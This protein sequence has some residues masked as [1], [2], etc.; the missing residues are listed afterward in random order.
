MRQMADEASIQ[1]L[2]DPRWQGLAACEVF[3]DPGRQRRPRAPVIAIATDN[4][5]HVAAV[6]AWAIAPV[7]TGLL[8]LVAVTVLSTLVLHVLRVAFTVALALS[9]TGIGQR[10]G[11]TDNQR[12]A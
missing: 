5:E 2:R 9:V 11:R 6:D 1:F 4:A 12:D 7:A 10:G 8:A 3:L